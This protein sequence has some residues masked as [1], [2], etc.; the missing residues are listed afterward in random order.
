MQKVPF[1]DSGIA[2]QFAAA[3]LACR[4]VDQRTAHFGPAPLGPAVVEKRQYDED[5]IVVRQ[6]FLGR[7]SNLGEQAQAQ[8]RAHADRIRHFRAR[9]HRFRRRP[10]HIRVR[11]AHRRRGRDPGLCAADWDQDQMWWRKGRSR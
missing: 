9:R 7:A 2:V 10:F 11:K 5:V 4:C 3:P 6:C 8:I 1:R